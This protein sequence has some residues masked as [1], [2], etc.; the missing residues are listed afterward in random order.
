MRHR[1]I[2]KKFNRDA[3]QRKALLTGLLRALVE[4]GEIVTTRVKAKALR[5]LADRVVHRAQTDTL[6]SRRVLHRTFGKR[7]VVNTLVDRVA[8]LMNDRSSG[9]TTLTNMGN[10]RGDNTPMVKIAFIKQADQKGLKSGRTYEPKVAKG[11]KA[12]PAKAAAKT[13][14]AKSETKP[15]V[16]SA[17][18]KKAK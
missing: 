13:P 11:T 14:A 12:A 10:R 2:D 6:N 8:P 16:K 7:D 18:A 15:A 17:A 4:Q 3:N 9:F 1:V 5:R